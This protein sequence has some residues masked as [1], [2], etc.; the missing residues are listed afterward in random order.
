MYVGTGMSVELDNCIF[1]NNTATGAGG[2][3]FSGEGA[4]A[5]TNCLFR[6]KVADEGGAIATISGGL[7]MTGCTLVDNVATTVGGALNCVALYGG[8]V[9]G[10]TLAGIG[11]RKEAASTWPSAAPPS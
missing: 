10:C 2:A 1:T 4:P 8:A 5:I 6:G 11:R 3:V 9:S 7:S